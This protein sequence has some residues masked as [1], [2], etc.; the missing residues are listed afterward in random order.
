VEKLKE[1]LENNLEFS[2]KVCGKVSKGVS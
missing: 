1:I 2:G